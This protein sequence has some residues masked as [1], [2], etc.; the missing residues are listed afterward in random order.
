MDAI[1]TRIASLWRR[2]AARAIDLVFLAVILAGLLF[3]AHKFEFD[4]PPLTDSLILLVLISYEIAVPAV[5]K[6]RSLGKWA[7]GI[8][9]ASESTRGEPSIL[10]LVGRLSARVAMFAV[11]AVFVAYGIE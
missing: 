7:M 6:G 1:Q 3:L 9:I 5:W 8:A 4:L 2:V 11:L 10:S